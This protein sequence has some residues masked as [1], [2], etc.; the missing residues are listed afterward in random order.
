[1]Q[2]E[3]HWCTACYGVGEEREAAT[4]I[5]FCNNEGDI[6]TWVCPISQTKRTR[7]GQ[8]ELAAG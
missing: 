2:A 3:V 1:M 5:C 6:N 8:C 4:E 7:Y